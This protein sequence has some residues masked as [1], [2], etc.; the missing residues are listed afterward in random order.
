[1]QALNRRRVRQL[2][3]C[4]TLLFSLVIGLLSLTAESEGRVWRVSC[5]DGEPVL[6]S[7]ARRLTS[8][9]SSTAWRAIYQESETARERL[10]KR[11]LSTL[12]PK[13]RQ[14]VID[15]LSCALALSLETALF[16]SD[17]RVEGA[18]WAMRSMGLIVSLSSLKPEVLSSREA[19]E[20]IAIATRRAQRSLKR[21]RDRLKIF[22]RWRSVSIPPQDKPF[23]LSIRLQG[24]KWVEQCGLVEG[25]EAALEWRVY[26]QLGKTIELLIPEA[27][28]E[29]DWSG[30][31]ISVTH[32]L[33]IERRGKR[34]ESIQLT[35]PPMKCR[36]VLRLQDEVTH[37]VIRSEDEQVE[38]VVGIWVNEVP[39][40][41][42]Q[43]ISI[44]E[45]DRVR[46]QW[47]GYEVA[48]GI[49]PA[50]GEPLTI[51]MKR[52]KVSIKYFV[53]PKDA[54]IEGPQQVYWGQSY[55]LKVSRPGYQG[56]SKTL[57]LDRPSQCQGETKEV[58]VELSRPIE[59][60]GVNTE[61]LNV[62]MTQLKV[63]GLT[64]LPTDPLLR[65]MG[66]YLVEASAES[67]PD[68]RTT[69]YVP[70][71]EASSCDPARLKVV[72][73]DPPPPS[74]QTG[75][76]LIWLGTGLTVA[77]LGMVALAY[78]SEGRVH[79]DRT[80]ADPLSSIRSSQDGLYVG[81]WTTLTTGVVTG[82]LGLA[83][84]ALVSSS[85]ADPSAERGRR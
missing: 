67:Y 63:G 51:T 14:E 31:C 84:P 13:E 68:V 27:E 25:C 70:S 60:I 8:A 18:L 36:S 21:K 41:L 17:E 28:Y 43:P 76:R 4:L 82:L 12:A 73:T 58:S 26:S 46:V 30:P 22:G 59:V 33:V 57:L 9:E 40:D 45:G 7:L 47:T 23:Q 10:T 29:L 24:K 39:Q 78:Q 16:L 48:E 69:L 61:G 72:F 77:G 81:G 50:R 52:C 55:P 20:W 65:P 35:P 6:K 3:R 49:A 38:G 75:D 44:P 19:R 66:R 15:A 85:D 11:E 54:N 74:P 56:L 80:Y 37:E 32:P 5:P 71:C 1:M 42:T 34:K 79:D 62:P 64:R 2:S 53:E 83:W